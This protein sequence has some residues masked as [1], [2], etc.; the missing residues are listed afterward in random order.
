MSA[1]F[2]ILLIVMLSLLRIDAYYAMCK[3]QMCDVLLMFDDEKEGRE[4]EEKTPN[5]YYAI[6]PRERQKSIHPFCNREHREHTR[7]S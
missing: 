1:M 5:V 6:C 2:R 7:A 4:E 3:K